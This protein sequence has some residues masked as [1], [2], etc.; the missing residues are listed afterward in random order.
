MVYFFGS[1]GTGKTKHADLSSAYLKK[2]GYKTWRAS[3]KYHHT[4]AY[5]L[6]KL[7]QDSNYKRA[8]NYY[9][10]DGVRV[11][12]IRTPWKILEFASLFPAIAYRVILP[13]LLGYIIV[14]DR[15]VIDSLV[16]LSYFL[17][18]PQLTSKTF[19]KILTELIPKPSILFYLEADTNTIL[20][21][22]QDEPLTSELVESYKLGYE[23]AI[24]Q[25]QLKTK[26]RIDTSKATV[27]ESQLQ[28]RRELPT[29]KNIV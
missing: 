25:L 6:L 15:Y 3:V 12:K 29:A 11:R 27:E 13:S 9:G 2:N 1:D 4:F 19:A 26:L 5:L 7:F 10:F 16:T 24:K 20:R 21:R 22:K 17:K 8:I 23:T 28:I 14:C 18:D